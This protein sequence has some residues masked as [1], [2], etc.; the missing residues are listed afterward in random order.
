MFS[1]INFDPMTI[2]YSDVRNP[3]WMDA[4]HTRLDCEVN[5]TH[6]SEEWVPFGAVASGDYPHTHRIFEECVAGNYGPI[7]EYEDPEG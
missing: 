2:S 6:I 1:H 7:A 4:E 5:F 3:K